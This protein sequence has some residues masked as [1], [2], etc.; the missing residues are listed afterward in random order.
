MDDKELLSVSPWEMHLLSLAALG[1]TYDEIAIHEQKSRRSVHP[2][3]QL[4]LSGIHSR[5]RD[6]PE[7]QLLSAHRATRNGPC[8]SVGRHFGCVLGMMGRIR[9]LDEQRDLPHVRPE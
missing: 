6:G 5:V 3:G 1:L 7:Q 9:A 4:F 2:P 8:A